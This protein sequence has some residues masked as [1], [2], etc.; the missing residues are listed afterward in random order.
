MPIAIVITITADTPYAAVLVVERGFGGTEEVG[1]CPGQ[2]DRFVVGE[3][4]V[5]EVESGRAEILGDLLI[6][7]NSVFTPVFGWVLVKG[8]P[9]EPQRVPQLLR[10]ICAAS[11]KR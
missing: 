5:G 4:A 1:G 6:S 9:V 11:S 3:F 2:G 8:S 7:E 10:I